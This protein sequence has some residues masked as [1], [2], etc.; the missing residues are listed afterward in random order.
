[1]GPLRGRNEWTQV[2]QYPA[3]GECSINV[4]YYRNTFFHCTSLY[5]ISQISRF[6]QIEGK[7][8]HQQDYNLAL[9][10][11][12]EMK[13]TIHPRSA[14]ILSSTLDSIWHTVGTPWSQ[15]IQPPAE[16]H[17]AWERRR[18][19]RPLGIRC[20]S[21]RQWDKQVNRPAWRNRFCNLS[22]AALG[23]LPELPLHFD[24]GGLIISLIR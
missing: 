9:L 1:M 24:L 20:P 21:T 10:R 12:F 3:H 8:F 2:L 17:P 4:T 15:G 7:T 11:R 19:G 23:L 22:L 6:L 14:C 16:R 13:P 18:T 5:C